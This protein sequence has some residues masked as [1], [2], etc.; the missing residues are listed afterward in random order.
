MANPD[1]ASP[2]PILAEVAVAIPGKAGDRRY[3]YLVHPPMAGRVK[4]GS[5]VVVPFGPG[6]RLLTGFVLSVGEGES[7]RAS[8]LPIADLID[9]APLIGDNLLE[10]ASWMSE[11]YF[12][13]LGKAL[14]VLFPGGS[15]AR[16]RL[17][18]HAC[19]AEGWREAAAGR[20][21][22]GRSGHDAGVNYGPRQAAVMERLREAGGILPVFSLMEDTGAAHAS[23]ASLA[24]R[25]V[26]VIRKLPVDRDPFAGPNGPDALAA[27][28]DP[29]AAAPVVPAAPPPLN[30]AQQAAVD[31]VRRAMEG[32]GTGRGFLLHG[33]T[34]SGKTEVYL[35][36]VEE[37]L[38]RG[39]SSIVLVPEISLTPQTV[40][41]F[42]QRFGDL[43]AVIHSRLSPGERHDAWRRAG[44]GRAWVVVGTRSAVFAPV[45]RLGLIVLDEEHSPSY[46]QADEPRYHAAEVAIRRGVAEGATVLLGSATPSLESYYAAREGKLGL[47][48]LP[49]RVGDLRMPPVSVVDMRE[50][51]RSGNRA[52]TSRILQ[53]ALQETLAQGGQAILLLNRR[54]EASFLLCRRCGHVPRCPRCEL[55][56]TGHHGTQGRSLRCHFCG[57]R[58]GYPGR[59]PVCG[60]SHLRELGAGTQRIEGELRGFFPQAGILRLDS[61]SASGKW[62]HDRILREFAEGRAGILLG[63]QMVA[64]GLDFPGVTLVGILNADTSLHLPDFRASERTFQMI[65]QVSGRTGRAGE[66]KVILQTYNPDHY[67]VTLAASHDYETFYRE[68][69]RIRGVM[70]FPPFSRL[71]ALH[72]SGP[73]EVMVSARAELLASRLREILPAGCD[74]LGPAPAPFHKLRGRYRWQ[75]VLR[76][77]D[78]E[79]LV[80][81]CRRGLEMRD[82]RGK[83]GVQSNRATRKTRND[84]GETNPARAA[85]APAGIRVTVD[86]DPVDLL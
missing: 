6:G 45:K 84:T 12:C 41:R 49:A 1:P 48:A 13:S 74:L 19:L 59:C 24:R 51:L 18:A 57:L 29:A 38:R 25:G 32:G 37:A 77:P 7:P 53:D 28:T 65:A 69:S 85:A 2:P 82:A 10:L 56:L 55:S 27:L 76:G 83:S 3:S 11:V 58:R 66:G 79:T 31:T 26:L 63:T 73:D 14:T 9:E 5:R 67:A 30:P 20:S 16:A 43:T 72:I 8:I 80:R 50:E 21:M 35:A 40:G 46:K 15:G 33:V 36:L 60:S 54:G 42:R 68:E 75:I 39:K 61:D 81:A 64:K 17:L 4:C 71:A 78:R 23:L 62:G 47:L 70:G 52:H 44:D 22:D 86:V 34:G